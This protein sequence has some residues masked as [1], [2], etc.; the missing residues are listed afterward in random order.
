MVFDYWPLFTVRLQHDSEPR[1][2]SKITY[3][4]CYMHRINL[5]KMNLNLMALSEILLSNG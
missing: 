2:I 4:N 3:N 5:E 1:T